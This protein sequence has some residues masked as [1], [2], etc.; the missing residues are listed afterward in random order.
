MNQHVVDFIPTA[1][2][3]LRHPRLEYSVE[4][5]VLGLRTLFESNSQY[6]I[7][8]V[9]ETFGGWRGQSLDVQAADEVVQVVR[10]KLIVHDHADSAD[11][12]APVRHVSTDDGRLLVHSP[13]SVAVVDP[14]RRESRAYVTTT[15][16]GDKAHF[17]EH[18]LE[19]ITFALLTDFDRHPVHA[20][21]IARGGRAI[22][23]AAPSG[24]GKSTIAYLAHR[25][26]IDVLG[27]D[28]VWI[29]REPAFRVWGGP[30]KVR[31]LADA[32]GH[33]PELAGIEPSSR[34]TTITTGVA[35]PPCDR[36]TVCVMTRGAA[37]AL[38]RVEGS[39]LRRELAQQLAPGFDRFAARHDDV[40]G[41]LTA[42]GGWRLTLS[43]NP[44]EALPLLE[45]LLEES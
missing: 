29:Q 23:L 40:V 7:D 22:L 42:D 8:V 32:S 38:E 12:D 13:G 18:I 9:G 14:L 34:K 44:S 37:V 30:L 5:C 33:F 1:D 6:V 15:L 36:A 4:F 28:H 17:R 41:A 19:A 26:G 16:A 2:P 45:R 3:L 31:L 10:V 39:Q 27:D 24:T 25:S 11:V 35:H 43:N 21:A 20:A